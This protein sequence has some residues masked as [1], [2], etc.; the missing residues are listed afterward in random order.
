[1]ETNAPERFPLELNTFASGKQIPILSL[2][3]EEVTLEDIYLNAIRQA[4]GTSL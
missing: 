2:T 1:V 4:G 3:R